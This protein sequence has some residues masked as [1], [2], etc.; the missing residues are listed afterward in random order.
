[1]FSH[2]IDGIDVV[3]VVDVVGVVGVVRVVD[4]FDFV[5][6]SIPAG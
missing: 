4:G 2:I 6:I 5:V 3:D 1:V